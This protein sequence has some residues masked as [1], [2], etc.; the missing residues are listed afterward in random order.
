[1]NVTVG[2][3][4][5]SKF[6]SKPVPKSAL[7]PGLERP[8]LMSRCGSWA[9]TRRRV[10]SGGHNAA[11]TLVETVLLKR[12]KACPGS[13]KDQSQRYKGCAMS[14]LAVR[15]CSRAFALGRIRDFDRGS[16]R[17]RALIQRIGFGARKP[18]LNVWHEGRPQ[19]GEA[20]LWMPL[21]ARIKP[22]ARGKQLRCC[23][24][25]DQ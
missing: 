24:R 3:G 6:A 8:I 12:V 1:M 2:Y 25:R 22:Q 9:A 21:A 20:P 14:G 15:I 19:V 18:M 23:A 17:V 16:N 11:R 7:R 10:A 13:S 4:I 5:G